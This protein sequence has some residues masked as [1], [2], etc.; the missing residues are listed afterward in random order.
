MNEK[1]MDFLEHMEAFEAALSFS[2][3][4]NDQMSAFLFCP[5][6]QLDRQ[7]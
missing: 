1:Q 5:S 7:Q 2:L 6:K 4:G 3:P